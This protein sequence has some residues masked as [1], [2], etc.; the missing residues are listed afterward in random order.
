MIDIHSHILHAWD[1]GSRSL[2]ESLDMLRIAADS[3]TTDIVATPHANA[4]FKFDPA[5]VGQRFAELR[6]AAGDLIRL[7]LGCDF[8]LSYEN[9][10]D[11]MQHPSQY[12]INR[13][14][15]LMVE[16]ADMVIVES[17]RSVLARLRSVGIVPV[18]THPERNPQ[19]QTRIDALALLAAEGCL[20]QVTGQ[21]LLGRFGP[22]AERCAHALLEQDLAHF[23]ASDAHDCH[24]RPPRLDLAYA[25]ISSRYGADCA[26]RL[27][28]L[29][30]AAALEGKELPVRQAPPDSKHKWY[31]F[32]E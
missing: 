31:K 8:H 17:A 13:K 15:Y 32:W 2:E 21:S 11:A 22:E 20:M 6:S 14:N 25:R 19:L 30:P 9:V 16:L 26:E 7:H 18:I 10:Q 4:E 27:F 12:T 28:V 24:D 1:D 23:I 29:N 3:G 5:M